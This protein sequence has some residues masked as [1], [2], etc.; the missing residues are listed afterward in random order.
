[1]RGRKSYLY[2]W[3][4]SK[5][6]SDEMMSTGPIGLIVKHVYQLTHTWPYWAQAS[7]HSLH[8]Q[9]LTS[10]NLLPWMFLH[11]AHD[12]V[13]W[14]DA[15]LSTKQNNHILDFIL[16]H[17]V[18]THLVGSMCMTLTQLCTTRLSVF[19]ICKAQVSDP[20]LDELRGQ[21][22]PGRRHYI[23]QQDCDV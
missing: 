9:K 23:L 4:R 15:C 6:S 10:D 17:L 11:G 8:A 18:G 1:M 20:T 7:L 22:L 14:R 12:L 2:H 16:H 3:L 13:C 21:P 19:W 5:V